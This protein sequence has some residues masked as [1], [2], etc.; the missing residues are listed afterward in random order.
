MSPA[1]W[2]S[3]FFKSTLL[4]LLLISLLVAGAFELVLVSPHGWWLWV[5]LF[6]TL[7][8]LVTHLSVAL[9]HRTPVFEIRAAP[10]RNTEK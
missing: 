7:V 8:Y 4:S 3:D 2:V 10:F 1:I 5:W 6:L 9:C